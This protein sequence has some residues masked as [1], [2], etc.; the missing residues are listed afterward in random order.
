MEPRNEFLAIVS[1]SLMFFLVVVWWAL[2]GAPGCIPDGM[3][4]PVCARP[5]LGVL[6][7]LAV[8]MLVLGVYLWVRGEELTK[9][10]ERVGEEE[11][12]REGE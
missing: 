1:L 5:D 11:E 7:A 3:M 4:L 6:S 9:G 10:G 2:S 8:V 12:D